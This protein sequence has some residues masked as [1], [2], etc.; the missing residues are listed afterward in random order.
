MNPT[1]AESALHR[2]LAEGDLMFH[3]GRI[4]GALPQIR[5]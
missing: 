2:A 4:G 5:R 3:A 1:D